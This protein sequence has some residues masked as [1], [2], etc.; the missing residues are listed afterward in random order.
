M[1]LRSIKRQESAGVGVHGFRVHTLVV[2]VLYG[3][4]RGGS[5]AQ[6]DPRASGCGGACDRRGLPHCARSRSGGSADVARAYGYAANLIAIVTPPHVP[7]KPR[8]EI[9]R[10]DRAIH[11][12]LA[13]RALME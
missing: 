10:S 5:R 7:H 9:L 11:E 1:A 3:G 2:R 13:E 12:L 4:R 8:R 6:H